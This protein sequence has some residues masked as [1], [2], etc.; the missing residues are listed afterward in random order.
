[1][2]MQQSF[3]EKRKKLS[4]RSAGMILFIFLINYAAMTFYWY[5]AIWWFDMLMHFLGGFWLGLSAIWVYFYRGKTPRQ[6]MSFRKALLISLVA[7]AA[8]GVS[9][10]F[11]EFGIDRLITFAPHNWLDTT[12]D[13]FF[14][15]AGGIVAALL[16][17]RK[18]Y[19]TNK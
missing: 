4:T 12:S 16:L 19:L 3:K 8:F 15:L 7:I 17:V 13:I 9:W 10:E 11:F 6:D 1:M 2:D 5:G 14:D 18:G